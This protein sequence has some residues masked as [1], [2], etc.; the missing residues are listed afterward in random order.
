MRPVDAPPRREMVTAVRTLPQTRAPEAGLRQIALTS[1]PVAEPAAVHPVELG[2]ASS[3]T[4]PQPGRGD[5]VPL[6]ADL[7]RFHVTVSRR[8]LEKLEA[9]R[10]A[11]SHTR[12]GA[13]AEQ[14][15]EAGLDL[16]LAE[17]AKKKGLVARPQAKRRPAK[18]DH[19]PAHVM[20][21]VWKRDGGRCQ[22]SLHSGGI[23]G[24]TE[25]VEVHH[26]VPRALGGPAT[27]ENLSLRCRF[28][29]DLEARREYGD[30]WMHRFTRRRRS[31]AA[32]RPHAP[33][34]VPSSG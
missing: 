2:R 7:S 29:N 20:R 1:S 28:H 24:S 33:S 11:L 5:A 26:I 19:V 22:H 16:V 13:S 27:V 21:E 4:E 14:I 9:A 31:I 32:G 17:H 18:P 12:P 34:V 3:R 10:A 6:T 8:F 23:C 30:E 15:L 25:R